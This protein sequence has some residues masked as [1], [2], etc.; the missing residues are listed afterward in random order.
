MS[1]GVA[2]TALTT[3][4][5]LEGSSAPSYVVEGAKILVRTGALPVATAKTIA[6]LLH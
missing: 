1:N 3:R 2:L 5:E 6:V 4:A